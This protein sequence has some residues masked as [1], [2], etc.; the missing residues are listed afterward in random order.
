MET[1]A[2]S[3]ILPIVMFASLILFILLY[4]SSVEADH[5][6]ACRW[7]VLNPNKNIIRHCTSFLS[8]VLEQDLSY[9]IRTFGNL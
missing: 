9:S 3:I 7:S 5:I 6:R 2:L 1:L 8:L 4:I